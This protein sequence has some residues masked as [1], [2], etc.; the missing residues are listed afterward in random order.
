MYLT[1]FGYEVMGIG[2][3]EPK[4]EPYT[5]GFKYNY[6]TWH[7]TTEWYDAEHEIDS[8]NPDVVVNF[9]AQAGLVPQS[10]VYPEFFYDTNLVLPV[11]LAGNSYRHFIHISS[12]EVYGSNNVAVTEEAPIKCSSPYAVSKAAAD[13]HLM[14]LKDERITIIR[15]SNCYCPGQALYRL[16]PRA[17]HA[18]ITG[19]KMPLQGNPS[20]S[21]LH[22]EDLSHAIEMLIKKPQAGIF[23]VGADVPNSLRSIIEEVALQFGKTTADIVEEKPMR[24]NEDDCFW[25]N[26]AKMKALGWTPTIDLRTGVSEMV[27]WGRKYKE[28]ITNMRTDYEFRP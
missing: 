3:S 22:A 8:F 23:N 2:R 5:L 6:K 17:V 24:A 20:K 10:W 4:E 26:S 16:I 13:L 28:Q 7:L 15:P 9:A 19:Q 25:I 12:S 18:C 27:A 11:R 1:Q 14:T 21:Y